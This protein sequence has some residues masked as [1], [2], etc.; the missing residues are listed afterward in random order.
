LFRIRKKINKF[1]NYLLDF[2]SEKI[3][4]NLRHIFTYVLSKLYSTKVNERLLIFGSTSGQAFSGNSKYLFLYLNQNSNYKCVWVTSSEKVLK[5]LKSKNYFV[6]SNYDIFKTIKILRAARFIFITHGFGDILFI[7][8]SSRTQLIR[9]DH[10]IVLKKLRSYT[11]DSNLNIIKKKMRKKLVHSTSFLLV[12]SEE[13]K[14]LKKLSFPLPSNKFINIGYPRNDVLV[15]C[16]EK[17]YLDIEKSLNLEEYNEILLYAPTHRSYKHKNPLKGNFLKKLDDFLISTNKVLLYKPHPAS[18]KIDLNHYDNL[19]SIDPNVDI[20]DL[21]IITDILITDYSGVFYDFLITNQSVIFFAYDLENYIE[22]RGL[23]SDYETFVPGPI[24]K[25]VEEL[26]SKIKNLSQW[27]KD[28]EE[29]RKHL[30]KYYNEYSD[31]NS[32]KKLIKFLN[33]KVS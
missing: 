3:G 2:V 32:T 29:K 14:R 13:D 19:K 11:K 16:T 9:L 24:V 18:K 5:D 31:G 21:L 22:N 1:S 28:Y 8:L 27:D 10:G 15:N 20:M 33:I 17:T 26:I 7:D 12:T 30:R 23:Y 4:F 6:V 25:T